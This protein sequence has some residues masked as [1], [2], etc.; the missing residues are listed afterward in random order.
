MVTVGLD[1]SLTHTGYAILDQDGVVLASGV[2]KSKPSGKSLLA[3]TRRIVKIA[4]EVMEKIDEFIE[5]GEGVLVAIEGLAFMAKGTSLVQLAGL[6]YLVRI[7]L[8]EFGW[9]FI[10]V[11]PTTL[12]KFITGSGKGDKDMM[13]MAVYKHYGFESMDNNECDAYS[14]AICGLAVLGNPVKSPTKPQDEVIKLI[15]NQL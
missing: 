4:E 1:L 13:M 14:L 6:N 15:Q 9:P 8:A 11:A 3:E 10:I 7:L 5:E 12:K 2:I